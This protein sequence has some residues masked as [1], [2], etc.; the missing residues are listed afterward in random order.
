MRKLLLFIIIFVLTCNYTTESHAAVFDSSEKRYKNMKSFPKWK[1]VLKRYFKE[2]NL[3]GGSCEQNEFNKCHLEKWNKKLKS[4]RNKSLLTQVKA[5]NYYMNNVKYVT[6]PVNWGKK[7]Y[8]STP[9]Q[10]YVKDGDCED[11][12]ITKFMSLRALGVPNE[13]MRIVILNDANIRTIHAV[14]AVYIDDKIYILDNQVSKVLKDT[15]IH[16]Y[17]PIYSINEKNWWRHR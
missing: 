11:Y 3:S 8:W 10:F 1:G 13:D 14:L 7:D 9:Y 5:V 15:D 17:E 6:D 12:A 4:L 16:H 2:E